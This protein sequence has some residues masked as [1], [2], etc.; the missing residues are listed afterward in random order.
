MSDRRGKGPARSLALSSLTDCSESGGGECPSWTALPH[1][2]RVRV[3]PEPGII[4]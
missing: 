1:G 3:G 4:S 2:A